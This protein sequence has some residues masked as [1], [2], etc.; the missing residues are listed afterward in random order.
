MVFIPRRA[1]QMLVGRPSLAAGRGGHRGPLYLGTLIVMPAKSH[2]N[3]S[4]GNSKALSIKNGGAAN[5]P[6]TEKLIEYGRT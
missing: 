1:K 4:Q 6:F 2:R 3:L 5:V